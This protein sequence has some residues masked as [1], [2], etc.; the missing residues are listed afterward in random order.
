MAIRCVDLGFQAY[1]EARRLQQEAVASRILGA[2]PDTLFLVEHE[3]VVTLGRGTHRENLLEPDR[4]PTIEV[5]RGGD[6][7]LHGPG[8]LVGY[9]ICLLEG[10]GRDL[11]AHLRRLEGF[12]MDTLA[13]FGLGSQRITGKTG[14]WISGRKIASLGVACRAWCTWHGF[15]LNVENRLE[16][17]EAIRPCGMVSTTMTSI[18]AELGGSPGM[19]AV[20]LEMTRLAEGLGL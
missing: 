13:A 4:F 12:V 16:D 11:H 7:T 5:E 17:F 20:K 6:V 1:E 19:A 14:V 8:Q 18:A 3:S 2:I 10:R 15:A 9:A